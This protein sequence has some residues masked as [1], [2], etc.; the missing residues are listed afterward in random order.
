MFI[1]V[2]ME[3]LGIAFLWIGL[4]FSILIHETGHMVG[5]KLAKGKE[6]WTIQVGFGKTLIK[7]KN[8]DIR[9]IPFSGM[10]YDM[11]PDN[12]Y[13]KVQALLCAAGGPAFNLVLILILFALGSGSSAFIDYYE[14]TWNFIR[15]Y[16]I[17]VFLSAIIPMRY[18]AF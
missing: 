11:T 15:T 2:L 14:P 3:I 17:I 18:P 4:A 13:T 16:N 9:T 6:D 8:Y 1:K 5:Y 12:T 10:F 7:T